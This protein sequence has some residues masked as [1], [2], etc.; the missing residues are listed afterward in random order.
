[1]NFIYILIIIYYALGLLNYLYIFYNRPI[2]RND[3][4]VVSLLETRLDNTMFSNRDIET[5]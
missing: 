4:Q 2:I 3:S 1:M 5:F